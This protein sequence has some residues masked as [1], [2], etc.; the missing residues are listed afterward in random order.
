MIVFPCLFQK[1]K[2]LGDLQSISF[3]KQETNYGANINAVILAQIF[4][5]ILKSEIVTYAHT[6]VVVILIKSCA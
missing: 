1:R 4:I 6:L 5:I 3:E 2:N